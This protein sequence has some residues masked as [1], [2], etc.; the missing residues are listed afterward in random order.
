MEK[1]L[2]CDLAVSLCDSSASVCTSHGH[3]PF[4]WHVPGWWPPCACDH[5]SPGGGCAPCMSG[6][7][8]RCRPS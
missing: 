7:L 2:G 6:C 1:Q 5:F 3:V 4:P 8:C